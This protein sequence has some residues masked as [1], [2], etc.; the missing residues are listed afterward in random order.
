[1][2]ISSVLVYNFRMETVLLKLPDNL[3]TQPDGVN[4][5]FTT[6]LLLTAGSKLNSC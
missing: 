1:M 4:I 5:V 6:W 3:Y 2:F